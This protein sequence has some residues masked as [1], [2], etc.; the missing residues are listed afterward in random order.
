MANSAASAAVSPT[1]VALETGAK[2]P[3]VSTHGPETIFRYQERPG[4]VH[5]KLGFFDPFWTFGLVF[6]KKIPR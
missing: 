3:E 1:S 4:H 5:K 6:F 2:T